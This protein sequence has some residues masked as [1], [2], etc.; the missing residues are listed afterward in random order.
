MLNIFKWLFN[1]DW[2]TFAIS[3]GGGG[4]TPK[5]QTIEQTSIPSYARPY[6]ESML[7]QAWSTAN[8]DY[9]K[10]DYDRIAG[11]SPLQQQVQEQVGEY[12][13]P[14]QTA[15]ASQIAAQ[16]A[17]RA[18][19]VGQYTAGQYGN[20]FQAPQAFTPGQFNAQQVSAPGLQQYQ[21]GPAERVGTQSFLQPGTT[22][23]YMSPYQQAV[24]DVAKREAT[25]SSNIMKQDQIAQSIRAGAYGGSRQGLVEA[26][27]Q[28]NLGTQLGDIQAQGSQAAFQNAQQQFNAEQQA[29]LQAN[30]ANQQAGL[31]VGQQNLGAL[32]GVQQ[33]G[34]GQNL[35]AQLANQQYGM[36]AQQLAEQSRQF[37]STQ[38][39]NAAQLAAQYGLAGQQLSEQSRQ[40]GANLGLQGLQQQ[41]QAAGLM[42]NLGQQQYA[43]ETG[44]MGLQ[45][46]IGAQQQ[47]LQQQY[48]TQDYQDF[49][50]QRGY[51][52]QQMG[53]FSDMLRGLPL[54]QQ[55]QSVY[56]APP[57]T[58]SQIA[59]AGMGLYGMS[60]AGMFAKG[61][62]TSLVANKLMQE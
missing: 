25:R 41:L 50:N 29:R 1:P 18:G 62:L 53:W 45:N 12:Q 16:A 22:E 19:Q 42:G 3:S 6:V 54:T 7:G 58:A 43:Q 35:Q 23:A 32:L 33:L 44:L 55:T 10:Y 47:A 60:R 28:R 17:A 56:Q 4:K 30:L 26:E 15:Q 37:G 2:F 49:L 24:T 38:G 61:G 20:Q 39:M 34:A 14:G 52:Q 31:S 11:F 27:R 5:Q 57:S 51:Q 21:M 9:Q 46:Q 13:L 36:T 59:G 48:L 8:Q 40:F